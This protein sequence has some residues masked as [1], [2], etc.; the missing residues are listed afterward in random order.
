[1]VS[2]AQAPSVRRVELGVGCVLSFLLVIR[3]HAVLRRSL[4][5]TLSA[6]TI[7]TDKLRSYGSALRNLVLRGVTTP[8][9]GRIT[10]QRIPISHCDN[11][12]D[13]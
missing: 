8:V 5:A 3:E 4:C 2:A 9:A 1:M 6:L 10:G 7:V 11:A 12:N 13:V